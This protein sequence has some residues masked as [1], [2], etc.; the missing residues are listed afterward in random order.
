MKKCIK[1]LAWRRTERTPIC[2]GVPLA[3][4]EWKIETKSC[5]RHNCTGVRWQR[6]EKNQHAHAIRWFEQIQ[7]IINMKIGTLEAKEICLLSFYVWLS[8]INHPILSFRKC[9]FARPCVPRMIHV[10]HLPHLHSY[11]RP[12]L[13]WCD[14]RQMLLAWPLKKLRLFCVHE[15]AVHVAQLSVRTDL[16]LI[17]GRYLSHWFAELQLRGNMKCACVNGVQDREKSIERRS[18]DEIKLYFIRFVSF[19]FY[20][21]CE[22]TGAAWCISVSTMDG[23]WR[24]SDSHTQSPLPRCR[25]GSILQKF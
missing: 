20:C 4:I 18:V 2:D 11:A 17:N 24:T 12:S 6:E 13:A 3:H 23:R 21:R 19:F 15:N 9:V 22:C 16:S 10:L 1:S 14:S 7:R 8:S 5:W 25:S